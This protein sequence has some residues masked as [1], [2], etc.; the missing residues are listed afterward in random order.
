MRIYLIGFMGSGKTT[1]GRLLAAK[2]PD[3]A[4]VDLDRYIEEREGGASVLELFEHRGEGH[5]RELEHRY[6]QEVMERYPDAVVST[7]GGT[8]CFN[9]NMELM[10][11]DGVVVY[12]KY[13]AGMLAHRLGSARTVRPLLQ[14]KDPEQLRAY[15]EEL[16]PQREAYYGRANVVVADPDKNMDRLVDILRPYFD[17]K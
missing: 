14:G 10:L 12:L 9:R 4:F 16:L 15:V 7:G 2:L 1:L 13:S 6:L 8:P 5:F 3:Y 11:A 17:R